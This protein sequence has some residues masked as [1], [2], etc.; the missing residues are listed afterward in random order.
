MTRKNSS[1]RKIVWGALIASIAVL[2]PAGHAGAVPQ[3]SQA[4]AIR[5]FA[6]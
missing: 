3:A 5:G 6:A 4:A 1:K 2:A